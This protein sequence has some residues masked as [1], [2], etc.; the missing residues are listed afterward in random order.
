M[1]GGLTGSS[2]TVP[3]LVS[4]KLVETSR[5]LKFVNYAIAPGVTL[6]G[7]LRVQK[8]VPPM[9]FEGTIIVG[10]RFA[11]AGLLGVAG[12]SVRGTLGGHVVGR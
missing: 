4:G 10:G 12:S 3:G 2:N 5:T 7:T 9:R 1:T 6:S 8:Y 11:A